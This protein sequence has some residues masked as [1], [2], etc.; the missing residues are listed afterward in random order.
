MD[1]D[2]VLPNNFRNMLDKSALDRGCLYGCERVNVV[3]YDRWAKLKEEW[4]T[5]PQF[6]YRYLVSSSPDLPIGA[7]VVHKQYGYVPIGFFQLW[8][9]AY[10]HEYEL[11][12]PETEGTAEN[13]DVQWALRWPRAKRRMLPTFRVFHLESEG[14][15]MGANWNGRK[16]KPFTPNGQPMPV[17]QRPAG[18]GYCS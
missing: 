16:T 4:F 5:D 3:G 13:M 1:A 15:H 12:Y 14:A 17:P 8:H 11:R 7:N 9:S 10:M 6:A 2:V 18:Y